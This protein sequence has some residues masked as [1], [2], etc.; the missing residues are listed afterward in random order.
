MGHC[1]ITLGR[2]LDLDRKIGD[3]IRN[4]FLPA[5]MKS[6]VSDLGVTKIHNLRCFQQEAECYY[7]HRTHFCLPPQEPSRF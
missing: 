6:V 1:P 5:S 3:A 7:E 2:E 4:F